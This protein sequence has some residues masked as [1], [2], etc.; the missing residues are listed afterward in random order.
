MKKFLVYSM[1]AFLLISTSVTVFA[2]NIKENNQYKSTQNVDAVASKLDENLSFEEMSDLVHE[3][4]GTLEE[5]TESYEVVLTIGD[6]QKYEK[7]K[8]MVNESNTLSENNE[9]KLEEIEE[10]LTTV[11]IELTEKEFN[12]F[13]KAE[14]LDQV[15]KLI[16]SNERLSSQLYD[17]NGEISILSLPIYEEP[18]DFGLLYTSLG[19]FNLSVGDMVTRL[20]TCHFE[21][22]ETPLF[23]LTDGMGIGVTGH[24]L[25]NLV[26]KGAQIQFRYLGSSS[27]QSPQNLDT[28]W[29]L[30]VN[31]VSSKFSLRNPNGH[32]NH[33]VT[34]IK[35][36]IG[37]IVG[38]HIN[39]IPDGTLISAV[40][41]YGHKTIIGGLNVSVNSSGISFT[42]TLSGRIVESRQLYI[43]NIQIGR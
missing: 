4:G 23:F 2:E 30:D 41:K 29:A 7:F 18:L 36:Q 35:G 38:Q 9:S 12:D 33:Y 21:W 14:N 39:A 26:E 34:G 37:M 32:P 5:V 27:Y 22:K 20:F 31:G 43:N 11:S 19:S 10:F 3:N 28:S 8:N 17:E 13:S 1:I 15:I 6:K 25:S 16:N 42:P 40:A 24:H